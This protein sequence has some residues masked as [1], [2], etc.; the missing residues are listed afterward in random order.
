[1][2]HLLRSLLLLAVT[3]AA[4]A[5]KPAHD[6]RDD[7]YKPANWKAVRDPLP[8]PPPTPVAALNTT[9]CQTVLQV[10]G[11]SWTRLAC[12]PAEGGPCLTARRRAQT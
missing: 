4:L 12:A 10:R 5:D 6:G 3:V 2:A 11:G 9:G 8:P 1:M 7:S